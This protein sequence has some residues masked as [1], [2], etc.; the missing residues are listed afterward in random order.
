MVDL[1]LEI[2][3]GGDQGG[4][5]QLLVE[6]RDL[7]LLAVLEYFFEIVAE[8][9]ELLEFVFQILLHLVADLVGAFGDHHHGFIHIVFVVVTEF[10][11][12]ARD[13]VR[14]R[15]CLAVIHFLLCSR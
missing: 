1:V 7:N 9:G 14:R 8:A 10:D 12:V 6:A 13:G 4:F 5:G 11:H 3:L 15:R 2:F